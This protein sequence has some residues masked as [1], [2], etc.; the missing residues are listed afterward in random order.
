MSR[1]ARRFVGLLLALGFTLTVTAT[2][3]NAETYRHRDATK[4]MWHETLAGVKIA[5]S[6]KIGDITRFEVRFGRKDLVLRVWY[7][8]VFA[9][10]TLNQIWWFKGTPGIYG[11]EYTLTDD[12]V[13]IDTDAGTFPTCANSSVVVD[14]KRDMTTARIPV[15]CLNSP[16]RIKVAPLF[17]GYFLDP[18]PAYLSYD[19]GMV[20]GIGGST[21]KYGPWIAAG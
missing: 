16:K 1:S 8:E 18:N 6:D 11:A 7:R 10:G 14:A 13:I 21:I 15:K 3:A 12:E 17:K 4:D 5:K 19:L 2:S 9:K 20:K